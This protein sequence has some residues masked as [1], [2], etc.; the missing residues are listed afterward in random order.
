MKSNVISFHLWPGLDRDTA[1]LFQPEISDLVRI[2]K[3][4]ASQNMMKHKDTFNIH[5]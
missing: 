2:S 5:S 1:F 4:Q 3:S